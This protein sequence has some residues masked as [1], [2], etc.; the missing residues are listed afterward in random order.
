MTAAIP[1]ARRRRQPDRLRPSIVRS[2]GH[3]NSGCSIPASRFMPAVIGDGGRPPPPPQAHP[4]AA[5]SQLAIPQIDFRVI[6][7]MT[8]RASS[9]D[10][11]GGDFEVPGPASSMTRRP[12]ARASPRNPPK[13]LRRRAARRFVR[14]HQRGGQRF[15][16]RWLTRL[17]EKLQTPGVIYFGGIS[18][19][20]PAGST[21]SPGVGENSADHFVRANLDPGIFARRRPIREGCYITFLGS[22]PD[23]LPSAQ[24]L[25]R[26]LS[27]RLSKRGSEVLR[28]LRLRSDEH[29]LERPGQDRPDR[30]RL[31]RPSLWWTY[32][33]LGE[34]RFDEKGDTLITRSHSSKSGW[35]FNLSNEPR[36]PSPSP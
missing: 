8:F 21:G 32:R 34:T 1:G 3:F 4:A 25:P 27:A 36:V 6:P 18:P 30:D 19:R 15:S 11:R 7:L 22:P 2:V 5:R 28:P 29:P 35:K 16:T 23:L 10:A 14:R 31:S 26:S 9:R 24:S 17:H 13:A 33:C 20:R 12:T